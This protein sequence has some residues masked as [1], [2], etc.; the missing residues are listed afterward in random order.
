MLL[1]SCPSKFS[2][3]LGSRSSL[4]FFFLYSFYAAAS[5]TFELIHIQA[6][7]MEEMHRKVGGELTLR[8][9][10]P[11]RLFPSFASWPAYQAANLHRYI[12]YETKGTS[13]RLMLPQSSLG[14]IIIISVYVASLKPVNLRRKLAPTVGFV[15]PVAPVPSWSLLAY[16]IPDLCLNS[17]AILPQDT[18]SRWNFVRFADRDSWSEQRNVISRLMRKDDIGS[19]I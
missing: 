18:W 15:N 14:E 5:Q 4:L 16:Q 19:Y 17:R 1:C 8:F 11:E 12:H 2:P 9:H 13:L 10:L 3:L 7:L 6:S